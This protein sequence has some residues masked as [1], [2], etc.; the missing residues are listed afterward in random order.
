M[1][2]KRGHT[3]KRIQSSRLHPQKNLSYLKSNQRNKSIRNISTYCFNK[4]LD[5]LR[6]YQ[7]EIE[8]ALT[9]QNL[10]KESLGKTF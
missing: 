4:E 2:L 5:R 1:K 10:G 8:A 7:K 6:I 3:E 9:K